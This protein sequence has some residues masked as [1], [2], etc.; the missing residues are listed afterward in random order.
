MEKKIKLQKQ[1]A[2]EYEGHPIYKY[3]LNVP[4]DIIKE[5]GWDDDSILL[6]VKTKNKKVEISK[7]RDL[8]HDAD[9]T[10]SD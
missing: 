9:S 10:A 8:T 2:Y 7:V 4:S 6:S 1:K 3:R 5:L